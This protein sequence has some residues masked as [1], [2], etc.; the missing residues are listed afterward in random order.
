MRRFRA[1]RI[2]VSDG[3]IFGKNA[4]GFIRFNFAAPR[5]VLGESLSRFKKAME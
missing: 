2:E 3:R 5:F 4:N 1:A